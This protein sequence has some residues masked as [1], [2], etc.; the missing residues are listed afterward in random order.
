MTFAAMAGALALSLCAQASGPAPAPTPASH[1]VPRAPVEK[2]GPGLFRVGTI[3]VD[4]RK[5]ELTLQGHVN[6]VQGVEFLANSR[7]GLKAYES[8]LTLDTDAISFNM[9]LVLIGLDQ[10]NAKRPKQHF[11]PAPVTGDKVSLTVEF[12]SSEGIVRGPV[13]KLLFD[14]ATNSDVPPGEWVYTGSQLYPDGR[15]A[16]E[17]EGVLIGFAHTP[18]S[19]VESAKG[20]ALGNYGSITPHPKIAA[21]AAV[22]LRI[23][24][25]PSGAGSGR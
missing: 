10:A 2:L 24:A 8:V 5:R 7:G 6:D 4:T 22:T 14:R 23:A 11:D 19:V 16:A 3:T 17:A 12:K 20:I 18:T 21:G 15:F 1:A 9:A 13:E 25:L